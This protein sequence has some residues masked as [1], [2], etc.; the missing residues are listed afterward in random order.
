MI[1]INAKDV[2]K[3]LGE[4]LTEVQNGQTIMITK[5]GKAVARMVPP[6]T[7]SERTFPDLS[8]F[9]ASIKVNS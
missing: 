6:E 3:R 1:E 5:R 8:D 9:R 2:R 7:D 4:L